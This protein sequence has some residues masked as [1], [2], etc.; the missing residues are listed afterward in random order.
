[1][2]NKNVILL[3]VFRKGVNEVILWDK[4]VKFNFIIKLKN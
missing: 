2:L 1:M 3:K 4:I